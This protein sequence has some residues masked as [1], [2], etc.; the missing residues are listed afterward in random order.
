MKKITFTMLGLLTALFAEA[1]GFQVVLQGVRQTSMGN[2]GSALADVTNTFYNPGA[3]GFIE[4]S[5]VAVGA[6]AIIG[7]TEFAPTTGGVVY[8]TDNP[9]S[10]PFYLHAM[11]GF[12]KNKAFKAGLSV[13]TPYGSSVK[14]EDGWVGQTNLE[15]ITLRSI[16][17][18]PTIAYKVS[19]KFSIGG[20]FQYMIGSVNLQRK[21][22][23]PANGLYVDSELDGEASGMG[24]NLGVAAKPFEN[25]TI[26]LAYRSKI[27]A[28]VT[29][30][31]A[32]FSNIPT[33]GNPTIPNTPG[34]LIA[35]SF[36][37]IN[38]GTSTTKFSS[39]LPLPAVLTL[40]L[41]W[42][43]NENLLFNID[44]RYTFWS[45]Y[46]ELKFNFV[47]A[48][49]GSNTSASPRLYRDR[50]T[51][52]VGA[53]YKVKSLRLRA[54][55]YFDPT[56]VTNGYMTAETPDANT[57]GLTGG[58]GYAIGKKVNIDASILYV[59]RGTRSNRTPATDASGALIGPSGD[60][61]TKAI[62]PSLGVSFNF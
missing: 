59:N 4:G 5:A 18:Q 43:A 34:A 16:Y 62:I 24:W 33:L 10:P 42:N 45:A 56:P 52:G 54:G 15:E 19:D 40:G 27:D 31:T 50:V 12:G 14:W 17:I 57:L 58:L 11:F 38:N 23:L 35:G 13:V 25:F 32:T 2:T 55:G 36:P 30:G 44:A 61:K 20:G 7:K 46:K 41:T 53:E 22:A 3:V 21:T 29:E 9:I 37:N 51:V 28:E 8:K 39:T 47:D 49:A 6:N 60:F 26:G 48:V 1:G